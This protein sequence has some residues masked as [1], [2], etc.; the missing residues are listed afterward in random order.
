MSSESMRL[1]CVQWKNCNIS[2]LLVGHNPLKGQSHHYPALDVE[3]AEWF[4]PELG[5][6]L[7]L[8][9]RCEECGINTAQFGAPNMHSVLNRYRETGGNMQWIAT[10]YDN[11]KDDDESELQAILA[12][13]P[14]PIGIYYYGGA[15]DRLFLSGRIEETHDNLKRLRDTGLL[16]GVG[17]HLPE[18]MEHIETAGWD[19]DFYQTCCY[20]VYANRATAAFDR[21][22]E[23]FDDNDRAAMLAFVSKA[24]K[25]CIVFKVLA[26]N[27]KCA[28]EDE[29]RAALELAFSSIKPMDVVLL[30][31]WQKYKDQVGQ[32]VQWAT[33][34][35]QR[36]AK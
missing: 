12:V 6:D 8:L 28:T 32:N 14:K 17:S 20:T 9:A 31:M 5:H 25:P 16:V 34:F 10:F 33:E 7:E 2:R 23:I 29:S 27:R 4:N 15:I 36:S 21:D 19:V 18:V 1:P 11:E 22:N 35:L 13:D 3:M 24:S 30:G 26:G